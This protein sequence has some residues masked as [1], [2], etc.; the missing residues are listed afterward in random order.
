MTAVTTPRPRALVVHESMFGNTAGV[1]AAVARGLE[2][3]GWDASS[4]DV[5]DAP[6]TAAE[7]DVLVVGAPTHGF[8]LSR[9]ATRE[10]AV[11]QGAA[12]AHAGKGVREWLDLL[13]KDAKGQL[14][15]TFDTRVRKVRRLPAAAP[16]I[17]RE[18]RKRR[19][20]LVEEATGFY[21]D[22]VAG[23]LIPDE[24]ERATAWGRQVA[25][26]AHRHLARSGREQ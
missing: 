6:A 4:V 3:E 26:A 12:P 16:K 5:A 21:V 18:L 8:S 25:S 14:A 9:P 20:T 22:D 19:F 17:A 11:R 24:V 13:P 2:L 10:D 1:A 15:A 23:P 7:V